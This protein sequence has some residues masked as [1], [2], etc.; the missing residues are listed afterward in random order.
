[1]GDVIS[2]RPPAEEAGPELT[3]DFDLIVV[4]A[5]F[6]G[7]VA[8]RTAAMRGLRVAVLDK[9]TEPGAD[10]HTTGIL[11]KEAAD[12]LDLPS[13]LSRKI[14]GVRLYSPSM[15]KLDL[16]SPGYYFL[17][18]DTPGLLRWLAREAGLAGAELRFGTAFK[19]ARRDGSRILIDGLGVTTRY[20]IGADGAKS[21]VAKAFGLGRNRRFLLGLEL[22]YEGHCGL[23]PSRLHC[24]LDRAL[25]PGY[26]AWAV[27]GLGITQLGLAHELPHKTNMAAL[28][29]KAA[30]VGRF[31]SARQIG[32]RG[33]LIPIGGLVRPFA[34]DGVL[35]IG[36]A[37][38][39]VSPATAGGIH[40]AFCY[41]R[42]AAQSV[43]DYLQDQG[44]EPS[45]VL[46]RE[47][48]KYTLKGLMRGIL[49]HG[50]PDWTYDLALQ[51]APMKALARQV[52][53]HHRGPGL[54]W[55]HRRYF[56]PA[57]EKG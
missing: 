47:L 44:P 45:R 20:L 30:L 24:F 10:V 23:D 28:A 41:G 32:R 43:C 25:A 33:G 37:A 7:L 56:K 42:R 34:S 18:T 27:P 8:A 35:L 53:F 3:G 40:N 39:T 9:K 19:G 12:S 5:G 46:A 1:M 29:S 4:G 15:A 55:C 54:G 16:D 52:Y 22:E 2:G 6:A 36:D 26:I 50:P 17:A 31:M 48:P 14:R 57:L 21:Q 11:V 51:T 13:E 49:R 38:G